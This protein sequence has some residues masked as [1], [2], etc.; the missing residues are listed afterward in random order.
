MLKIRFPKD[1]AEEILQAN[2]C[3]SKLI[4]RIDDK[5]LAIG[6]TKINTDSLILETLLVVIYYGRSIHL[7]Y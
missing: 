5:N 3:F 2:C 4:Q 1:S 6:F 7:Y